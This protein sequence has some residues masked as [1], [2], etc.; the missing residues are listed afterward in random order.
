MFWKLQKNRQVA[1]NDA[2]L[3]VPQNRQFA[4]S[5]A[6]WENSNSF[7]LQAAH[8]L[9][10]AIHE[11]KGKKKETLRKTRTWAYSASSHTRWARAKQPTHK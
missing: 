9:G 8:N 7:A 3:V 6:T 4:L 5:G 1:W 2:I 10:S 11:K